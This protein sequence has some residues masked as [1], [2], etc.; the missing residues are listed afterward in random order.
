M[1]LRGMISRQ[2]KVGG[3]QVQQAL[4]LH[5]QGHGRDQETDHNDKRKVAGC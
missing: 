5:T 4:Q 2:G 1:N 3:R